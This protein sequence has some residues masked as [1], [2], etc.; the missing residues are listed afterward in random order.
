MITQIKATYFCLL[1]TAHTP[2]N[3]RLTNHIQSSG[4]GLSNYLFIEMYDRREYMLIAFLDPRFKGNF[5]TLCLLHET[6]DHQEDVL[7]KK[8]WQVRSF[9]SF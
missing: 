6:I 1:Y 3:V 4:F 8:M 5:E 7:I 9:S 2:F